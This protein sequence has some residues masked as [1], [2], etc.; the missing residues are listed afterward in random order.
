LEGATSLRHWIATLSVVIGACI[1]AAGADAH[2]HVWV[3][4]RTAILYAP[5]G[6][7]TGLR[8]DW[9]FDDMYSAFALTGVEAKSKG[10]FTRA[11][12]QPL[13]QINI[14]SLKDFGYFTFAKLDG[15]R[16]QGD[17]F[18]APVDYWVDYDSKEAELTLHFTLPFKQPVAAKRLIVEIYDPEF[19]IDFAFAE[20]D[21]VKLVGAPTQCKLAAEKPQDDNFFTAQSLNRFY[22]PSEANVGMGLKFANKI[23]VECP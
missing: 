20:S 17:A 6:A 8:Q 4:M 11:E 9:T 23:S 5:D 2:P 21:A 13:A 14:D 18:A 10:Q 22:V 15:K 1:A 3:T 7:V 12:L 16:R 19:F